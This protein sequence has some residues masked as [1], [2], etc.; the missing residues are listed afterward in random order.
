MEN[1][2]ITQV[3]KITFLLALAAFL[4]TGFYVDFFQASGVFL[5]AFWGIANIYFIKISLEKWLDAKTRDHLM[6]FAFLQLKF[7]LLYLVGYGLL[8][9]FSPL[10]LILGSSLI[11]I[12]VLIL[13]IYKA[14]TQ[15]KGLV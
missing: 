15:T 10:Y 5:G 11:F 9:M 4:I 13:G 1:N 14:T 6:L 7:P 3:I 12:A 2:F 8:K